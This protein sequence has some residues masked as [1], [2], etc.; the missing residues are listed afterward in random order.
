MLSVLLSRNNDLGLISWLCLMMYCSEAF[1]QASWF[2]FSSL[3]LLYLPSLCAMTL[4]MFLC[5]MI[6]KLSSARHL[7]L[8]TVSGEQ[9]VIYKGAGYQA[10][11][12]LMPVSTS[13]TVSEQ[14]CTLTKKAHIDRQRSNKFIEARILPGCILQAQVCSHL[15]SKIKQE[16]LLPR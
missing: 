3:P 6:C 9:V 4:T 12:D 7:E 1:N 16:L 13:E 2:T 8:N 11:L 14:C 5:S 15:A 10:T